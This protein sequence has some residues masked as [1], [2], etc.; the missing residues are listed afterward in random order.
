M[1][2]KTCDVSHYCSSFSRCEASCFL[3]D[4]PFSLELC[5]RK[6]SEFTSSSAALT[7]AWFGKKWVLSFTATSA[8]SVWSKKCK[9]IDFK[10]PEFP[11]DCYLEINAKTIMRKFGKIRSV[12]WQKPWSA[13]HFICYRLKETN[14]F[15][16]VLSACSVRCCN[17]LF[18]PVQIH[19]TLFRIHL[20]FQSKF[21][22][23]S[24]DAADGVTSC[25]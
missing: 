23:L 5:S 16:A 19:G 1:S 4:S 20:Y 11:Q 14:I 3:Q 8:T 12:P 24:G 10:L 15:F 18:L 17:I 21:L 13:S 25:Y 9:V 6:L 22:L 2:K 7:G